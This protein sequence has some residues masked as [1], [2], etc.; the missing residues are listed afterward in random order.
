MFKATGMTMPDLAPLLR[1]A[2]VAVLGA[3]T[4]PEALGHR[5][6]KNLIAVG[7][8]GR[9]FPVHPSA[10]EVEGLGCFR[11]LRSLPEVPDCVAVALAADRVVEALDEAAR[12]G[13]RAAVVFASG[14]AETGAEGGALQAQLAEL[15][16]RTGLIVCGPNCLGLS[17]VHGRMALY[18]APLPV[19]QQAGAV[20]VASHSGS[21]CVALSSTGRLGLSHVVSVGNGAMLDVDD[22]LGFFA[23]D[24]ATRVA[25]L[26]M[27]SVRHPARFVEAARRM[28]E[29]GKPVVVLKVGRSAAGAAA[30]AAHTG[31]L[32]GSHAA[33][34]DFFHRAGVVL[35]DDMDELIETCALMAQDNPAP[36]GEG[37]AVIN[38]S[39]GEVALTCDLAQEA[40][41]EFAALGAPTLDALRRCLPSYATPGNPLD[42]TGT[43]VSDPAMYAG[44]IRILLADPKVATLAVSQDCPPGL[45]PQAAKNYGALADAAAQVSRE[46]DKPIVFYSNIGGGLHPATIAP[47]AGTQVAAL[48]GARASL[49]A[50]AHFLAWHAWQADAE[51]ESASAAPAA[52][53]PAWTSRFASGQPLSEYEAKR[54]LSEHGIRVTRESRAADAAQAAQAAMAIGF[55]VAMKVDSADIAHKTEAG[56][57]RLHLTNEADVRAAFEEMMVTVRQ[58][59]PDARIDGVVVQ[60]MVSSGI[61]MIAGLS[62]QAPFGHALIAGSG[63]VMVEL[64]RDSSLALLPVDTARAHA[65]VEQTRAARLLDGFRGAP[66]ADRAAFEQV[67]VQLA[68]IGELYGEHI[69]A[70]DLNPVA[71]LPSGAGACALDAWIAL[72]AP[73]T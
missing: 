23:A 57:V 30:S 56:G 36:S 67:L 34:A 46:V 41:V 68:R 14:F 6:M 61:E 54:F 8:P 50:I 53:D 47:L 60:E 21:A 22:Y 35:V 28:R 24:P 62:R 20:A 40:G 39:G 9:I 31:S 38:I 70:I 19:P 27:E 49:K 10:V 45:S 42:A 73:A 18:S 26:F 44:A 29:A 64:L 4:R 11:D 33:A 16:E 72:R 37:I 65:L 15:C 66:P 48:Q 2:S 32:A 63:G 59:V 43:A 7:Y 3:S 52:A 17:N 12:C 51:A 5:V 71:V 13:I 1:P 25:A 58:R 69:E 55:P